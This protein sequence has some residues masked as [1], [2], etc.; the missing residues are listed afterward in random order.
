MNVEHGFTLVWEWRLEWKQRILRT[1]CVKYTK[2]SGMKGVKDYC[3]VLF[4][5]KTYNFL[6][7][8]NIMHKILL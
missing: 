7:K 8:T 2:N 1:T 4:S 6:K 5:L 3:K